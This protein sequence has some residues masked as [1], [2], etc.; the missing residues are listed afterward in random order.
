MGRGEEEASP[1]GGGGMGG[2]IGGNQ[3][4]WDNSFP[5]HPL[6]VSWESYL[7]GGQQLASSGQKPSES[8]SELGASDKVVE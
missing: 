1:G 3:S 6:K 5:G 2:D 7:D 4:L 8:M